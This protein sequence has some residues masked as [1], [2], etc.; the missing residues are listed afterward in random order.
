MACTLYGPC[1]F[2]G[3]CTGVCTFASLSKLTAPAGDASLSAELED[4]VQGLIQ[5]L[6][7]SVTVPGDILPQLHGSQ[8]SQLYETAWLSHHANLCIMDIAGS[9]TSAILV[10]KIFHGREASS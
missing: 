3:K 8:K 10:Q 1:V 2:V 4:A 6:L 5:M 7:I 9:G